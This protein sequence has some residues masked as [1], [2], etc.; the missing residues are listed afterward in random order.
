MR[1]GAP[2]LTSQREEIMTRSRSLPSSL[3]TALLCMTLF[4]CTAGEIPES[5]AVFSADDSSAPARAEVFAFQ[6]LERQHATLLAGVDAVWSQRTSIDELGMSHTRVIQSVNDIPVFGAQAII[7]TDKR[8]AFIGMTDGLVRG[9]DIDT[10]PHLSDWQATDLA[11]DS[12]G[13][14]DSLSDAPR[15]E[16]F[17]LRRDQRDYLTYRVELRQMQPGQTPALPVVFIDAH[18]GTE[19]WRYSQLKHWNLSHSNRATYDMHEGTSFGA[20]TLGT[21]SDDVLLE[22]H[23]SVSAT[24]KFLGVKVG[25]SSYDNKG[26]VVKSYGHYDQNYSNGFW[27][28]SAQRLVLGDGDG[29]NFGHF[30]VVDIVAHEIGHAVVDF[31]ADLTYQG[32]SGAIDE[33]NGD[34]T[35]AAVEDYLGHDWV[36][37]IGEDCWLPA[38][39]ALA[40]RYMSRPSDDGSSRDHYA[41]RY[42]GS[43]DNGGVHFN[44]GIGNHFFYLLVEGGKHHDPKLRSGHTIEGIGMD[45][46]YQIWYRAVTVYM[47]PSTNFAGAREA[48]EKACGDLYSAGMCN[49]VSLAW[50]EVGVGSD[51]TL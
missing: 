25:R 7:H 51:P 41:K 9:I 19:I 24:L 48:T 49:Q 2:R 43:A 42:T 15:A 6:H 11:V 34:V 47:V 29:T 5:P 27:D 26:T 37:D 14:W 20:A 50:Y 33:T 28:S 46:A 35:A 21:S 40:L 8:G 36:F 30:G 1:R 16:L 17:I 13:G 18:T 12:A 44:S 10:T 22:T 45:A 38:N 23:T 3:D 32:E 39:A 31:E 4:A